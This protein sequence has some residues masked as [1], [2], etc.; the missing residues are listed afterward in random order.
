MRQLSKERFSY[1][2]TSIRRLCLAGDRE[3]HEQF[4]RILSPL[5]HEILL[6]GVPVSGNSH[7]TAMEE[8]P[9]NALTDQIIEYISQHYADIR[10]LSF[11]REVFHYSAVHVNT[12]LK[13]RLGVS[14]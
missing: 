14:L 9:K 5:L 8:H 4:F 3:V 7:G 13:T 10:D 6:Y 11:V 12:L 1:V 2:Y